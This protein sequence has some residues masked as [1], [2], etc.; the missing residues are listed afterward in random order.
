MTVPGGG[1]VTA[2]LPPHPDRVRQTTRRCKIP[3]TSNIAG[4]VHNGIAGTQG[5]SGW[6]ARD[7]LQVFEVSGILQRRAVIH[8]QAARGCLL[9][10]KVTQPLFV[11]DLFNL[12]RYGE[13]S[14]SAGGRLY[15]F[16][17][18]SPADVSGSADHQQQAAAR[19]FTDRNCG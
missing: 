1:A 14:L 6:K 19:V 18:G 9:V 16:T 11:N 4:H 3:D 13:I 5:I 8:D 12:E 7:R 15:Q 10:V 17:N 2:G